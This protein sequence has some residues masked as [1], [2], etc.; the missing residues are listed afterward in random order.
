V[1]TTSGETG[2]SNLTAYCEA[3]GCHEASVLQLIKKTISRVMEGLKDSICTPLTDKD[4]G[5]FFQIF[6]V[7]IVLSADYKHGWVLEINKAP[8]LFHKPGAEKKYHVAVALYR[9][10][11]LMG[12]G[13]EKW[14]P[15]DQMDHVYSHPNPQWLNNPNNKFN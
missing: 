2:P 12:S 14:G 3:E 15:L 5:M 1:A 13:G 10:A 9:M 7:D 8:D 6:G 4:D 11:G